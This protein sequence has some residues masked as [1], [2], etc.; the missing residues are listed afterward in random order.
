MLVHSNANL[1]LQN[2]MTITIDGRSVKMYG[3]LLATLVDTLG[4][5]QLGGFKVGVGFARICRTC[6]ATKESIKKP[7]TSKP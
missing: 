4:A 1:F 3:A 6:M 7:G 5:H 2:G